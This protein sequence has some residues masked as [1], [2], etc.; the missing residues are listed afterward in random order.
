VTVQPIAAI[1]RDGAA[2]EIRPISPADRSGVAALFGRMSPLSIRH[3]FCC[4][5]RELTERELTFMTTPDGDVHVALAA[6]TRDRILG[7]GHYVKTAAET[8]EV[9]FE[10][11][12]VDQGRGIGTL[13]LE[14]LAMQA[15]N[16]GIVKFRA[17]VE[18]DNKQ[19]L[20]V[21]E[22]SGFVVREKLEQGVYDVEFPIADTERF[23]EAT[24][25]RRIA[26]CNTRAV[27][28]VAS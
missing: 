4:C 7:L 1:L 17:Q 21:F 25:Q 5:K 8:A 19:M 16:A 13:L 12:D 14:H 28:A 27:A 26:A 10:V 9:A 11:G 20:E 15:R 23:L 6:A 24:A 18:A 22:H 3:R 2:V